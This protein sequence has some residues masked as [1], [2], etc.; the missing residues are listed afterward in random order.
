MPP[1]ISPKISGPRPC[2]APTPA[3]FAFVLMGCASSTP[4][5]ADDAREVFGTMVELL[6]K[7]KLSWQFDSDPSCE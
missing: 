1:S 6:Q 7:R 4:V 2:F 5:R 3:T